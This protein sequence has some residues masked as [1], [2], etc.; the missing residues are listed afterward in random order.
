MEEWSA[1]AGATADGSGYVTYED[2]SVSPGLRYGYGLGVHDDSGVSI[3]GEAWVDIPAEARLGLAI[4]QNPAAGPVK[5]AYSLSG[6]QPAEVALLDL[7]GR[8]V[9]SQQV[10]GSGPGPHEVTLGVDRKLEPGVCWV[11]L[12]QGSRSQSAKVCVVR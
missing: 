4:G 8:R 6:S 1:V 10:I 7:A 3:E 5:V 9:E 11:R 12:E 2:R